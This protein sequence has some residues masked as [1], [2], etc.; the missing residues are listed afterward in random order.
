MVRS[1]KE[2]IVSWGKR[3]STGFQENPRVPKEPVTVY[4]AG[5]GLYG[6]PEDY[7]TFLRWLL[8]D[9]KYDGGQLL[10]PET[11]QM[12]FRN[13][14][15][16]HVAIDY[17]L[18]DTMSAISR[19]FLDESDKHG[20]AWAIE[21]NDEEKIRPKGTGYWGGVANT[22]YTL[23]KKNGV[24]IVYFSQI[25]PFNDE[26]TFDLFRLFEKEVY[27]VTTRHLRK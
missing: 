14:L 17:E 23:D 25:V 27:H 18:P 24:A 7:L 10:K 20:L 12:M 2:K 16:D 26:E 9:G 1:L 13:E 8:N 6:S 3:D 21:D 22:Y 11:A 15:P 19:R 5:G 4:S